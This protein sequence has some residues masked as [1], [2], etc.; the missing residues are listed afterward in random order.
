MC[1]RSGRTS[2][3]TKLAE[4]MWKI[5]GSLPRLREPLFVG[6]K[7]RGRSKVHIQAYLCAM[8]QNLKRL[9]YVIYLLVIAPGCAAN[10]NRIYPELTKK[11]RDF[12]NR[13]HRLKP[14]AAFV[15]GAGL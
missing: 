12:F 9:V 14:A 11:P 3:C 1:S 13:P 7:Y 10:R 6:A 5:E 8:A 2:V 4:R 15:L